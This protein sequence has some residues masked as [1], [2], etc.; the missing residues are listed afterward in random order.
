M[1]DSEF[2]ETRKEFQDQAEVMRRTQGNFITTPDL[3]KRQHT[4]IAGFRTKDTV[5]K[6]WE[7]LDRQTRK[8]SRSPWICSFRFSSNT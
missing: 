1:S 7:G 6:W 5:Y 2:Q 4:L 3:S 8:N